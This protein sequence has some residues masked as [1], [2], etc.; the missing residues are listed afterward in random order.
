LLEETKRIKGGEQSP[1]L[2]LVAEALALGADEW[3]L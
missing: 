3:F 2:W 1:S